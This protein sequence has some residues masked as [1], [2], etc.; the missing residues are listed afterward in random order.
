MLTIKPEE[1]LNKPVELANGKRGTVRGVDRSRTDGKFLRIEFE[2][3]SSDWVKG[4][5]RVL[6]VRQT[7]VHE[8]VRNALTPHDDLHVDL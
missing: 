3:G 4:V 5:A 7:G 2:D 1:L 8:A 6:E